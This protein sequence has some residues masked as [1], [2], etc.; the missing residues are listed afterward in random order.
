MS[1]SGNT[2]LDLQ[3]AT[4]PDFNSS[5][6]PSQ[7]FLQVSL[8][9][10]IISGIFIVN[11]FTLGVEINQLPLVNA[12]PFGV[13]VIFVFCACQENQLICHVHAADVNDT[14]F[15]DRVIVF[16]SNQK[17]LLGIDHQRK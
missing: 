1:L 3:I 8:L 9:S 15:S 11:K 10:G 2:F 7:F 14:R 6:N 17:T 13:Q 16:H 5:L 12:F 4:M